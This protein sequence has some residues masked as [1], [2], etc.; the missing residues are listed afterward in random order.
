ME[1]DVPYIERFFL[2]RK[3]A[4]EFGL[5]LGNDA[6]TTRIFVKKG[7][8][9]L[10]TVTIAK[11]DFVYGHN[12]WPSLLPLPRILAKSLKLAQLGK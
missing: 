6:P 8:C 11:N 12:Q 4:F 7:S 5:T 2:S 9:D 1:I 3:I 10:C